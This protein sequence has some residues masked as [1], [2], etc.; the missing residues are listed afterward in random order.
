M[1]LALFDIDGTLSD[2]AG[3][4]DDVYVSVVAKHL[5][6]TID[7]DWGA[8]P[9]ASDSAVV[10]ELF[11]RHR[12]RDPVAEEARAVHDEYVARLRQASVEG[13]AVRGARD[14]L[15][16]LDSTDGWFV[17]IA[18]GNWEAPGQLKL[19]D[20]GFPDDY[21]IGSADDH[22]SREGLMERGVEKAAAHYGVS[23]FDRVVYVGD[24]YWDIVATRNLGL[25]F[26]GVA[27]DGDVA[28]LQRL[29]ASHVLEHFEDYPGFL[30]A[31]QSATPPLTIS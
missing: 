19:R 17:A 25:P 7:T 27:V 10:S 11:R 22:E 20:A 5:G 9:H 15:R 18:T 1:N 30:D 29:G 13:R 16:R 4:Y 6:V 31:L 3:H 14:A 2:T 12:G 26:V 24:A 23:A 8:Y 21:P 28:R